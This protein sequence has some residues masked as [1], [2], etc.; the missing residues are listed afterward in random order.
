MKYAVYSDIGS[1]KGVNQ[2]AFLLRFAKT[3]GNI[4]GM[5][6]V[7]DGVSGLQRGEEASRFVIRELNSMFE[8]RKMKAIHV[9]AELS[10]IHERLAH[11]ARKKH[12]RMGT[13]LSLLIFDRSGYEAFQI[14]DSRMYGWNQELTQISS[15]QTLAQQKLDEHTISLEE[16]NRSKERHVLTQCMGIGESL[17]IGYSKGDSKKHN[18]YFLCS[19]GQYNRLLDTEIQEAM[20][21]FYRT[22]QS[23][24]QG[25]IDR[26]ALLAMSRNETDNITSIMF[27]LGEDG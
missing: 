1:G 17:E 19:D 12:M 26:L 27:A 25:V 23:D 8:Q 15:D 9:R 18:V 14:G 6:A 5:A 11:Y 13:T 16:F 2:D 3:E 24:V 21:Q 20:K 4:L 7:C 10:K 22:D